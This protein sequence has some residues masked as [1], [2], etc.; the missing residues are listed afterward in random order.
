MTISKQE[1]AQMTSF[2][3]ALN[4]EQETTLTSL[5]ETKTQA[6][7]SSTQE[8]KTILQ[9][10]YKATDGAIGKINEEANYDRA[11]REAMVT[12]ETPTGARIGDWEIQ[13]RQ[14]GKRTFF[15]VVHEGIC[16]AKD[17]LLHQAAHGLVRILNEGGRLNSKE[18]IGLLRAEQD[19][20]AALNDAITYKHYMKKNPRD[21]RIRVFEAKYSAAKQRAIT[22]RNTVSA[23]SERR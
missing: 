11:L 21:T 19:Y 17:L 23:I 18:A 3:R 1:V 4:P 15:D 5:L 9:R 16:I 2:M 8:M 7:P 13:L 14:D 20:A 10:F 6:A 12:E 22:A